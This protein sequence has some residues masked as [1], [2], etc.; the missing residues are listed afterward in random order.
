MNEIASSQ[1][2]R[3]SLLHA[4][5]NIRIEHVW[6]LFAL[7]IV[8]GF[9]ALVPTLPND[10][11]WH[12]AAGRI[13]AQEGIP[14]TNLFAWSLPADTPYIYQ[15]WLGEWLF[16]VLYSIGG[17]PLTVF[18]RNL[19]FTLTFGLMGYDAY[20]RSGS[21]RLA[22]LAILAAGLMAMNNLT[23]RTQN[24]SLLP[25]IL[26]SLLLGSYIDGRLNQRWLW[27]IPLLMVFWVNAHGAFMTGLLL[28]GAY[29]FAE[30]LRRLLRHSRALTWERL[31]WLYIVAGA[32]LLAVMVNP[33]G[34][35]I[36][37][38]VRLLLSDPS[39][40]TLINE[41]QPPST[42]TYAGTA[43]YLAFLGLLAAFGLA[44]R[45]P[46]IT[47]VLLVC[48]F[49]W[50]AIS[51]QRYVLWFG[52]VAMPILAQSL[53]AARSPLAAS[54]RRAVF[55]LANLVSTVALLLFLLS[56]QPW[57]KHLYPWPQPYRDLFVDM[58]GAPQIFSA[59]TPYAASEH[60]RAQP[61]QGKLFNEMGQGSYLAWALYPEGQSFI[62]TRV[63]LFPFEQWQDYIALSQGRQLELL[64]QK[65]QIAC[66]M[67]DSVL[68]P[69]LATALESSPEWKLSFEAGRAQIWRR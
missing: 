34:P 51:G 30:T 7:T 20:R 4:L 6:A 9:V 10:F 28:I 67:L 56:L 69:N 41:W 11:W 58:P 29:T 18:A 31:R 16:Y 59:D 49:G 8:G 64:D 1:Q 37:G 65:Y 42:R 5:L 44:R 61:C 40:Q 66:V 55:P 54:A 45:R 48:G 26:T 17:F 19:L 38:Y 14:S 21:W 62:D 60:L 15:S 63:E 32:S 23:T 24:W 50:M 43:F 22:A 3:K 47:D 25:F 2:S 57:T 39:S 52:L 68:Q 53:A 12:L 13:I 46:T 33:L 35:R 36:F 27:A